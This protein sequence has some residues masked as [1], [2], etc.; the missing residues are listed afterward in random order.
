[1]TALHLAAQERAAEAAALLLDAGAVVDPTDLYGNTPL[2][3]AIFNSRGEGRIIGLLRRYGADC[4]HVNAAG[5]TPTDLARSIA[6][7]PI[8]QSFA[9]LP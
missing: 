5:Q 3:T 6:N 2:W 7:Y 1:M 8:A 4:G 9:D